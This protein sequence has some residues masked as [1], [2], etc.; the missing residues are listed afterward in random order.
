MKVEVFKEISVSQLTVNEQRDRRASFIN[1]VQSHT[2]PNSGYGGP[3]STGSQTP[4]G[5]HNSNLGPSAP[6]SPAC[7]LW[8]TARTQDKG[9]ARSEPT[10]RWADLWER[11]C[12]CRVPS[13]P[14]PF[15]AGPAKARPASHLH[16]CHGCQV[17]FSCI[18]LLSSIF[19]ESVSFS[20]FHSELVSCHF[21]EKEFI[22]A[23]K[24]YKNVSVSKSFLK[25]LLHNVCSPSWFSIFFLFSEFCASGAN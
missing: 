13:M 24:K 25:R 14:W 21:Y 19:V 15:P 1:F 12:W 7:W 6:G 23:L 20:F 4:A 2:F 16:H 8:A 9:E 11:V 17:L 18:H 10:P 3:T 5:A 22:G